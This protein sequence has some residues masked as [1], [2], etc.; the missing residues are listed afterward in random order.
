M[1]RLFKI[2]AYVFVFALTVITLSSGV[3][4]ERSGGRGNLVDELYNQAERQ[5]STL[6]SIAND[7]ERFYKKETDALEKYNE[8]TAYHNHY[9]TD[10]KF[11]ITAVND[12][13]IKQKAANVIKTS[14]T[15]YRAKLVDWQNTIATLYKQEQELKDL[16]QLL[17]I[18]TTVP[19]VEKAQNSDLPSSENIKQAQTDLLKVI[20][21]I[22]EITK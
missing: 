16:Q 22:K 13:I 18:M 8:F 20:Q 11:S 5:N 21:K 10:A 1:K 9:Y 7:I 6:E 14:E 3:T 15:A 4:K 17:K 2:A 12:S 19:V